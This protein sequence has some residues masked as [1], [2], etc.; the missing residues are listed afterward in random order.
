M[1]YLGG[2]NLKRL[3]CALWLM[4]VSARV[5]AVDL[6]ISTFIDLDTKVPRGAQIRL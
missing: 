5:F 4:L 6:Q 3:F 2:V 1:Q